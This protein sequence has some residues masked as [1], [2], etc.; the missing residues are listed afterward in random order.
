MAGRSLPPG[1]VV[2]LRVRPRLGHQPEMGLKGSLWLNLA[3]PWELSGFRE[4][5]VAETIF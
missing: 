1:L 3:W 5:D 2:R 4:P